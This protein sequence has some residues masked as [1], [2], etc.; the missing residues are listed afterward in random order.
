MARRTAAV[1]RQSTPEGSRFKDMQYTPA[2]I[3]ARRDRDERG[4]Y[5]IGYVA[6]NQGFNSEPNP[7]QSAD[8]LNGYRRGYNNGKADAL[9]GYGSRMIY[10][11]YRGLRGWR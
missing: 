5:T 11:E 6:G 1:A 10:D 4:G 9:C 2:Q 8:Y 7:T 3:Q